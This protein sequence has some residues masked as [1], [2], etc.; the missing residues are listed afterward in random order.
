MARKKPQQS[1][2]SSGLSNNFSITVK[3]SEQKSSTLNDETDKERDLKVEI[4]RL[5]RQIEE[6]RSLSMRIANP[7]LIPK[8]SRFSYPTRKSKSKAKMI[9]V[10]ISRTLSPEPELQSLMVAESQHFKP[11]KS[12]N[13]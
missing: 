8:K 4:Q 9:D 1:I 6:M 10:E 3:D 13:I 2:Q 7:H 12:E 11:K 5:Y